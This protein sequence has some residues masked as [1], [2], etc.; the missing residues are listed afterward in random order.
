[1]KILN[2][3]LLLILGFGLAG[4]CSRLAE[5]RER[6][7]VATVRGEVYYW[8]GCDAW[9]SLAVA[10]L[11]W[12]ATAAEAEA[13]GYRRPRAPGCA[14]PEHTLGAGPASTGVC[15]IARIVDG[16]TVVCEEEGERVRLLLIDAP[17]LSQGDEGELSKRALERLL[18]T[19]TPA[20]VELDVQERDRYGRVL[21]YLYT[22]AGVFVNEALAREGVAVVSV[23]PPNVRHVERIRQAVA[24]A[25]AEGRGFW[26]GSAFS[27]DPADHRAGRCD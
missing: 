11:Q 6:D 14:G 4:A 2:P 26:S 1:M 17:E 3:F 12:F 7:Y 8:V 23:H 13:A 5:E 27:C 22:P 9:R 25:R 24:A 16:D 15:T 20:R 19:G 10:N 18:P 21:A